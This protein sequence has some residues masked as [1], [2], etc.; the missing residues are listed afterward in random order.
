VDKPWELYVLSYRQNSDF[1]EDLSYYGYDNNGGVDS[2]WAQSQKHNDGHWE[3][4]VGGGG[5]STY[6]RDAAQDWFGVE[7]AEHNQC[8]TT[9]TWLASDWSSPANGTEDTSGSSCGS[10]T[11]IP[12]GP[13]LLTWEHCD[14]SDHVNT[15]SPPHITEDGMMSSG[16]DNQTYARQA[17]AII[18]LRTGGKAVPGRQSVWRL[19]GSAVKIANKREVPPYPGR[20]GNLD[21]SQIQIM[22]QSLGADWVAWKSLP[23]GVDEDATARVPG[24]DHYPFGVGPQKFHP[25]IFAGSSTSSGNL[26]TNT[27]EFCVGQTVTFELQGLPDFV[28]VVGHWNLPGKFVND[29]YYPC[30]TCSL[31]YGV[32]FD[33]LTITGTENLTTTCWYV[34]KPGGMVNVNAKLHFANGQYVSVAARGNFTVYRPKFSDFRNHAS[35][36]GFTWDAPTL[37]AHMRWEVTVNSIY[38]GQVGVTQILN[39]DHGVLSTG[40]QDYLD[41]SSELYTSQQYR[42][43]IISDGVVLLQDDPKV[44]WYV[45]CTTLYGN[46]TDYLRFAPD[47]GIWVTLGTNGWHMDGS[48]CWGIGPTYTN[49]APASPITDSDKFPLWTG[50]RPGS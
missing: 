39:A 11:D 15:V 49:I 5:S 18:K 13:P 43:N 45:G 40:G 26:D 33:L 8:T 34:N 37:Q 6:N 27:P 35:Y 44:T 29:F 38:S 4:W 2:G 28:D 22:G 7:L 31:N 17:V 47:G 24:M 41:G 46:Y 12:C 36:V 48:A 21:P 19:I 16:W 42:T 9:F 20:I 32:N 1:S 30:D 50:V 3:E 23:D 10:A 25:Y 14:V